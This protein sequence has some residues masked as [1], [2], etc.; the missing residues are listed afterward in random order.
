MIIEGGVFSFWRYIGVRMADVPSPEESL[1]P[2]AFYSLYLGG[3]TQKDPRDRLKTSYTLLLL[4]RLGMRPDEI[5][6]LHDGWVDWER[7]AIHVPAREPCACN[8]CWE[9]AQTRQ[10]RGDS[11]MLDE[12]IAAESWSPPGEDA[13]RRLSFGWSRRLTAAIDSVLSGSEFLP[14]GREAMQASIQTAAQNARGVDPSAVS[15]ASLRSSAIQFLATAGFGPRRLVD[16][17]VI[18]EEAAGEF[19]R[20][21]G[22]E[23]RDHLYRVLGDTEPPA[24]CGDETEYRIVCDATPFDREPFDPREYDTAWRTK[25]QGQSTAPERNPRPVSPPPHVSFDP[26]AAF[27][28]TE[29]S[30]DSGP[31][32]VAES[33]REWVDERE[34]ERGEAV[35]DETGADTIEM[36]GGSVDDGTTATAADASTATDTS[37]VD[38]TAPT[39]SSTPAGDGPGTDERAA[40]GDTDPLSKVT[41]PVEFSV[42]T[43]FVAADFEGG[44]PTGG[45]VILGQEELLFLSRTDTGV[46]G[47]LRISLDWIDNIVPGYVPEQLEGLFEDTVGLAYENDERQVVV[48]EIPS[49]HR[50]P[51]T[52]TLFA[53]VLD[54]TAAVVTHRPDWDGSAGPER[55]TIEIGP[56]RLRLHPTHEAGGRVTVPLDML[57]DASEGKLSGEE[58]YERGLVLRHLRT[59]GRV[60]TTEVRPRTERSAELLKRFLSQYRDRQDRQVQHAPLDSDALSVLESLSED[61]GRS[62]DSMLQR[63]QDRITEVM[64]TLVESDMV[65]DTTDGRRLTGVGYR[66]V[67]DEFEVG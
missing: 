15:V 67:S 43:R 59:N 47:I 30:G 51:F 24:I 61:S 11:R 21:G 65:V 58:G 50:W 38:D 25:R 18:D 14:G 26:A 6:H 7:G 46:A 45:S 42:D 2:A 27:T 22:G 39:A 57:V 10:Q 1:S 16:L 48:T 17:C 55:R 32:T 9:R 37:T 19:A 66:V 40:S 3:L 54:D 44:T 41:D 49:E 63:D 4:G 56:G 23:S 53:Y 60:T 12:I 20:V 64:N 13:A 33:L 34:Q 52:R 36:A 35:A 5:L 28:V 29:P 31:G 8:E 62:L